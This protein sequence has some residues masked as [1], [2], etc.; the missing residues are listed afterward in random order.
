[1]RMH[2]VT[3][4]VPFAFSTSLATFAQADTYW[5]E[6]AC[7]EIA[8]S[9]GSGLIWCADAVS[10]SEGRFELQVSWRGVGLSGKTLQKDADTGNRNMYLKDSKGRR[11]DHLATEG[12]SKNGGQ[13]DEAHPILRGAFVFRDV[14]P[15]ERAFSFHDDDQHLSITGITLSP[16]SRTDWETSLALLGH[17]TQSRVIQIE[18]GLGD[19]TREQYRLTRAA[20]GFRVEGA[21]NTVL[22]S[23]DV[24]SFLST[25]TESP[26][27][28]RKY[29][30][31]QRADDR[32]RV[33]V[34]LSTPEGNVAFGSQSLSTRTWV[35]EINDTSYMI[36]D[37]TPTRALGELEP[38]LGRDPASRALKLLTPYVG[39]ERASQ[40]WT[41]IETRLGPEKG[42][43]VALRVAELL[44]GSTDSDDVWTEL[45]DFLE[46][47][48]AP[49]DT[50]EKKATGDVSRGDDTRLVEAARSGD[51]EMLQSLLRESVALE[52]ESADGSTAL[53]AAVASSHTEAVRVLLAAGA[54]MKARS[55]TGETALTLAA[56]ANRFE[57]VDA[58]LVGGAEIDVK[59]RYRMSP[60]MLASQNGHGQTVAALLDAGAAPNARSLDG[61]T[62]LGLA[63]AGQHT[64]VVRLLLGAGAD[65]NL[66]ESGKE[67]PLMKARNPAIAR[68][69]LR[70]GARVNASDDRGLTALMMV[71]A[72]NDAR[73]PRRSGAVD[74]F[75]TVRALLAAG[76]DVG[77]RDTAKRTALIWATKGRPGGTT[78][79][80]ILPP[81]IE[82]GS[83]VDA[84][85]QEDATPLFYAL[86]RGDG[87]GAR[88]LVDAG[89]DVNARVG[90][91][92]P[93]DVALRF[94]HSEIAALLLRAGGRR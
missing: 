26:L 5:Q 64:A 54:D 3:A 24:A 57:I 1:M 20:E 59:G 44:D 10:L 83:D 8:L 50:H 58:L 82:A 21:S 53:L 28:E 51:V 23:S 40:V 76:A 94:G 18:Y 65:P 87:E 56:A 88:T 36:P 48:P 93:M 35:A 43:S 22:P 13:L 41:R 86:V 69:L 66:A 60:L 12:A 92:S 89:A 77:A 79:P 75:G 4:F 38:L 90:N 2:V 34:E 80:A 30:R 11:Y 91:L 52:T 74:V 61:D 14:R 27:L 25:L 19:G 55:R 45:D 81:L 70:A 63:A 16:H 84:R 7:T 68:A 6:R 17:L 42:C 39:A 73:S 49:R 32:P 47:R 46:P 67:T 78:N 37:D 72:G 31:R 85:D 71:V 29:V 15:E 9:E 33:Y 62:G